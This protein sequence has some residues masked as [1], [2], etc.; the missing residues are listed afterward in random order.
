MKAALRYGSCGIL[1]STAC[2]QGNFKPSYKTQVE[3]SSPVFFII[4]P[5]AL[6]EFEQHMNYENFLFQSSYRAISNRPF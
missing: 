6:A 1:E 2:H 5:A 3:N 4:L